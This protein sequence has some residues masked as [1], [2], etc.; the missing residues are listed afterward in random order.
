MYS[1]RWFPVSD[2]CKECCSV[3]IFLSVFVILSKKRGYLHLPSWPFIFFSYRFIYCLFLLFSLVVVTNGIFFFC[4]LVHWL[5][6]YMQAISYPATSMNSFLFELVLSLILCRT[7][8]WHVLSCCLQIKLFIIT[9][10]SL[11]WLDWSVLLVQCWIIVKMV[12][13][14]ALFPILVQ[15]TLFSLLNT[16]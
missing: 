3:C 4:H 14:F 11:S 12:E 16:I 1:H 7:C 2:G 15:M 13:I 6:S 9:L 5:L 10:I 8:P